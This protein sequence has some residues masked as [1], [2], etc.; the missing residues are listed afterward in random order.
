MGYTS[1]GRGIS[2]TGL[3]GRITFLDTI[4]SRG[5]LA[6]VPERLSI[7]IMQPRLAFLKT[8]GAVPQ[9]LTLLGEARFIVWWEA[10]LFRGMLTGHGADG[11]RGRL[12]FGLAPES[13]LKRLYAVLPRLV[14]RLTNNVSSYNGDIVLVFYCNI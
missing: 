10:P 7:C 9:A 1:A 4:V 14:E 8:Q 3:V 12:G 6:R 11:A 2:D 5:C 13:T